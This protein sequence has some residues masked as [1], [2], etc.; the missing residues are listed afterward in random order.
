[1]AIEHRGVTVSDTLVVE[2][3]DL[4]EEAAAASGRVVLGVTANV[5]TLDVLDGQTLDGETDVV[6]G[7]SLGHLLVVHLDGLALG[8]LAVR[9]EGDG[10][11]GLEDTGLNAADGNSTDT[12]DL[13]HILEGKAE[14]LV[15]RALRGL[16]GVE[17]VEEGEADVLLL[18][19]V[20]PVHLGGL[21]KKVVTSPA[22][23]RDELGLLVHV[24]LVEEILDGVA[25]LVEALLVELA[26][27]HLVQ[28]DNELLH[29]EGVSKGH[30]LL[31][32]ALNTP[33]GLEL[34][35]TGG[36]HED[37]D[38]SLGGT[39]D[40]VLDEVTVAGGID[41]G[42]VELGGLELPQGDVDGDTTFALTLQ[43]VEHPR[44]LEGTLA[45]VLGLLLVGG[46]DTLVDTSA[47]VDQV[48]GGGRLAGVDVA[49]D[50]K[51]DVNLGFAHLE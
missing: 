3:D 26:Q 12:L 14:R 41:D 28:A 7:A 30:V 38:V 23:D 19:A 31:G 17:H 47:L 25:D 50:H 24:L 46:D 40:H 13:V 29:T 35:L 39:G 9:G 51:V 2:D 42:E 15:G 33:S 1:M 10:V 18:V 8:G 16:D 27:V 43:L 36:D 45:E 5:A 4:G 37:R 20:V 11:S 44:V 6:S 49:D 21:L 22:G 32:G 34:T 48:T